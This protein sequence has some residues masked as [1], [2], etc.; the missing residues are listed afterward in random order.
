MV[1]EIKEI[2]LPEVAFSLK[3]DPR[4]A[5][6]PSSGANFRSARG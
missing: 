3:I 5:G 6:K 2:Q 4:L 1:R